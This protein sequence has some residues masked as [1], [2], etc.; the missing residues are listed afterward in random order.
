MF[1]SIFIKMNKKLF[2]KSNEEAAYGKWYT[3]YITH[4]CQLLVQQFFVTYYLLHINPINFCN[5]KVDSTINNIIVPRIITYVGLIS[6]L[7][8]LN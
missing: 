4:F 5:L 1:N 2:K 8:G 3:F 6:C 7:V